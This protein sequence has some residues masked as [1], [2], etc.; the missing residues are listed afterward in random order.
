MKTH[1]WRSERSGRLLRFEGSVAAVRSSSGTWPG[2]GLQRTVRENDGES[3]TSGR[4]GDAEKG[5][6]DLS[7]V[8]FAFPLTFRLNSAESFF[9]HI[10]EK[11]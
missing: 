5:L 9:V 4:L 11:S 7:E 2:K 10:P 6:G 8:K 1:D 3:R